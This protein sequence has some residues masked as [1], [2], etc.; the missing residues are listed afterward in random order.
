MKPRRVCLFGGTFDP[1]HQAHLQIADEARKHFCLDRVIFIPAAHPPHKNVQGLTP[2]EHRFAMVE[3]ACEP[4]PD[5]FVSRMEEGLQR[6]YTVNTLERFRSKMDPN[7]NLFFLIGADA[8]DDLQSWHRWRD[9][10]RMT[11]FIVA[12]RP[13]EDYRVPEGIE[14]FR[15]DGLDLPVASTTIRARLA[16]GD[17]TPELPTPVRAYIA[18]H[19]LYGYCDAVSGLKSSGI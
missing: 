10:V 8:F 1:I 7:E 2:F 5:F 12:S 17:P 14:V 16:L 9:V 13:G 4:Y 15:L 18:E 6:S 19:C 11:K 3:R